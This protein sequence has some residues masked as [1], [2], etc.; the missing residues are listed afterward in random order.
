MSQSRQPKGVPV[1]GQYAE[2]QHDEAG[3]SLEGGAPQ[4]FSV[5]GRDYEIER[6]GDDYRLIY[7]DGEKRLGIAIF[8]PSSDDEDAIE[9][10][11]RSALAEARG[12]NLD[13]AE[14]LELGVGTVTIRLEAGDDEENIAATLEN[15]ADQIENGNTSGY[16]PTWSVGKDKDD[17]TAGAHTITIGL[18]GNR[19]EYTLREVQRSVEDGNTS[20]YYPTWDIERAEGNAEEHAENIAALF[21]YSEIEEGPDGDALVVVREFGSETV[22][23]ISVTDDGSTT[24]ATIPRDEWSYDS[25]EALANAE[26]ETGYTA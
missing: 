3:A 16:Y 5:A 12:D 20:G 8:E 9:D 18:D 14:R 6:K 7:L 19:A 23:V 22:Y 4:T 11:A 1:G 10:A 2:N 25:D 17:E 26:W 13:S 21:S 15:I 24:S